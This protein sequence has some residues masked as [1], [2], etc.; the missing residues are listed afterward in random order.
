MSDNLPDHSPEETTPQLTF[1]RILCIGTFIWS[2]WFAFSTFVCG[3]FFDGLGPAI[4]SSPISLPP[5]ILD[6]LPLLLAAGRWFFISTAVFNG[7]SL[8]GAIKMWNLQKSGF[9]FYAIAQI[10]LLIIPMI[11]IHGSTEM[12]LQAMVS[13][14]FIFAYASNLKYMH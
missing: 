11:F 4:K 14:T 6:S 2:G 7:L 8:F 13:A 12:L 10:I 5:E 3:I 9:H 1:F